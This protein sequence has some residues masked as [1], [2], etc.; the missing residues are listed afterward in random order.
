MRH[1]SI[2]TRPAIALIAVAPCLTDAATAASLKPMTTLH[3]PQVLL[4]DLF[5][6][7]GPNANRTLGPGPAPGGRIIVEAAQLGAI[8]RQFGVDWRPASKAD[9]AMLEWPGKPMAR[10]EAILA[11]RS[12]LVAAGASEDCEIELPGFTSPTVPLDATPRPEV[13]QLDYDPS[14]GR[15]SAVLTV[16]ADGMDPINARISGRA[17]DVVELPVTTMRL[18]A[19]TILRPEDLHVVR[20]HTNLVHGEAIRQAERAVGLQLKRQV[21]VGVPLSPVDL[22]APTLVQRGASVEMRLQTA[23]LS[24]TGKG[25]ALEAGAVGERIRVLN[26]TSRAVVDAE[27]IGAGLVRVFPNTVVAAAGNGQAGPVQ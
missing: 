2:I 21:A 16:L 27:V 25:T 9:R 11:V 24:L 22:V 12:A 5:D 4:S 19:G 20:I 26:P 7:A 6:A 8:A 3:G 15:F 10:A 1:P 13:S 14:S 23:G 18:S 17:D